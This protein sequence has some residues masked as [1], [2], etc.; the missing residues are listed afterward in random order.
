MPAPERRAPTE[1]E[2]ALALSQ[3]IWGA[4]IEQ[5]KHHRE[6]YPH[7]HCFEPRAACLDFRCD[8][9]HSFLQVGS[10]LGMDS[11][12]NSVECKAT[13]T[14]IAAVILLAVD[15]SEQALPASC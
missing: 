10:H 1:S 8:F 13:T 4:V 9:A 6:V 7:V 14:R 15:L 12:H 11:V 5:C 2:S 3:R